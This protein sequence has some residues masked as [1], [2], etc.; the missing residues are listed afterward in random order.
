[1]STVR[2]D[3]PEEWAHAC[4]AAF[5]PLGVRAAGPAFRAHL[6][7]VALPGGVRVTRVGSERS[8]VFRS[9]RTIAQAPRDDILLAFHEKGRGRVHQDD[10]TV[11]LGTGTA[12]FYD[13]AAPYTLD[14]PSTMIETIVQFPRSVLGRERQ[15]LSDL[16]AR[17]LPATPITRAL[18]T[19]ATCVLEDEMAE[20]TSQRAAL[21]EAISTL[22]G[23]TFGRSSAQMSPAVNRASLARLMLAFI[24][25]HV[26]DPDLSPPA[27]AAAHHVSIRSVHSAFESLDVSAAGAIRAARLRHARHLLER[28][29]TVHA[30]ALASGFTSPDTFTRA[31]RRAFGIPPS[32]N[33][34]T[35]Q[36][37]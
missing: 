33:R 29:V 2:I 37:P 8:E 31:H 14:F 1:M 5:V 24:D 6:E 22:L 25:Q 23:G 28:G 7:Q 10:R 12:V 13:T 30:A 36:Q 35:T 19:L 4:S 27:L 26:E 21:G 18:T 3:S 20:D 17:S 32:R 34:D 9:A 15:D 16:T 11:S